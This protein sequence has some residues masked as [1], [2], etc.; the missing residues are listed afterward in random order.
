MCQ[1]DGSR[2]LIHHHPIIL[3]NAGKKPAKN[4]RVSHAFLPDFNVWPAAHY[5]VE[6]TT[7]GLTDIVF[8]NVVP[9]EEITISYM[10]MPP[11][12]VGDV[13][14]GIRH[15]DGFATPIPVLLQRVYPQW[16]NVILLVLLAFGFVAVAYLL[17]LFAAFSLR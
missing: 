1:Q 8:P 4:V 2:S 12:T 16:M 15:D 17:W 6:P 14:H 5:S 3:R 10:Y 7:G 9:N 11:R 13:N